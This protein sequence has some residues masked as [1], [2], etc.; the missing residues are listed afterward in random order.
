MVDRQKFAHKK[1][2]EENLKQV[3]QKE[4]IVIITNNNEPLYFPHFITSSRLQ[5]AWLLEQ[6]GEEEK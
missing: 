2:G 3:L 4:N 6:Q 5:D 1:S